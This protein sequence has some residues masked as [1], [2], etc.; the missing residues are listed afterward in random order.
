MSSINPNNIDGT[1]P[2]AG[3]DNDSQGFRDNFTNIKN[4]LTFAKTEIEDVQAKGIFKT[5][6]SGT[7][8]DNELSDTII[9]GAQL[10]KYRETINE[11]GSLSGTVTVDWAD[12]HLQTLTLDTG[13]I[14][15]A[16]TGWP[17]SGRHTKLRLW[18]DVQDKTRTLTLPS[19]VTVGAT[20]LVGCVITAG[21]PTISFTEENVVYVYEFTSYD[22]GA[23]IAVEEITRNRSTR[24]SDYQYLTPGNNSIANVSPTV[25]SVII[26]PSGTIALANIRMPGNTQVVDGQTVAFAFGATITAV[27]HYGNGATILGGLTTANVSAGAKY[28]YKTST[29]SWYK[30]G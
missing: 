12:A 17:T 5:A 25:S 9:S 7:T 10:L 1:Y 6:L 22:N 24:V 13:N 19:V 26:V 2:I 3:Q 29:N 16:L 15:L 8:L 4:N 20:D 28:I 30:I 21:V 18:I 23:T 14:T 27:T 11:L